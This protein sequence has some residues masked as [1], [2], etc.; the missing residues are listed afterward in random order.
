MLLTIDKL[1]IIKDLIEMPHH[2]LIDSSVLDY[3][4]TIIYTI[5]I[6]FYNWILDMF[7]LHDIID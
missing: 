5:F 2:A 4:L 6:S 7:Y 1:T 3:I